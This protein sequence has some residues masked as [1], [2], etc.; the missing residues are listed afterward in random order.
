MKMTRYSVQT[1]DLIFVKG[2][3]FSAFA[4]N[5]CRNIAKNISKTLISNI[6]RNALI[7]LNSLLHMQLKL[8]QNKQ[9]KSRSRSNW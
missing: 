9:F 1:R 3:G 5:A 8:L 6:V 4:K 7:M 2:Y